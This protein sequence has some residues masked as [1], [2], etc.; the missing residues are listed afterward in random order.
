MFDANPSIIA[1][2][3][4]VAT[5]VGFNIIIPGGQSYRVRDLKHGAANNLQQ[6]TSALSHLAGARLRARILAIAVPRSTDCGS[7]ERA[8]PRGLSRIGTGFASA[9]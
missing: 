1:R 9:T 4:Q 2:A 6:L 8:A 5:T 3:A 7:G